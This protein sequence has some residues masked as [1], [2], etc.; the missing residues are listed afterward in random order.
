MCSSSTAV[1]AR[2]GVRVELPLCT[3]I[4]AGDLRKHTVS[5]G[6]SSAQTGQ[7]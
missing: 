1:A 6:H 3:T 7:L 4:D 5:S 2:Q